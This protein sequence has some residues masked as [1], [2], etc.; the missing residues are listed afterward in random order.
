[1]RILRHDRREKISVETD[2]SCTA[3]GGYLRCS[4]GSQSASYRLWIVPES[5]A[6]KAGSSAL[7]A[8]VSGGLAGANAAELRR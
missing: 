3:A 4:K 6:R 2:R 7:S 8:A 5:V 1:M